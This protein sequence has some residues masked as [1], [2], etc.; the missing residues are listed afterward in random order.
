MPLDRT[1]NSCIEPID[2]AAIL[3]T[4]NWIAGKQLIIWRLKYLILLNLIIAIAIVCQQLIKLAKI[5]TLTNY[6]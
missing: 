3:I 2:F 1:L 5:L 6:T 4:I